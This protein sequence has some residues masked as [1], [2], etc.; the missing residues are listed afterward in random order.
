M[1]VVRRRQE[2]RVEGWYDIRRGAA[3]YA[4]IVG[5]F[6]ALSVPAIVFL[7]TILSSE[8]P[9]MFTKQVPV[10]A[11]A[12]G[13]LIVVVIGS[14]AG[15]IGL[16]AIGAERDATANL[17]PATMFL[18]VAVSISLIAVLAAFEALATLYLPG[19]GSTEVLFVAIV[20]V[21]GATGAFFTALSIADSWQTGPTRGRGRWLRTQWL[22]SYS[23]AYWWAEFVSL[24]SAIPALLGIVL[25]V[26]VWP[27]VGVKIRLTT[28]EATWL[29]GVALA[30]SMAA[31]AMGALR[32]RHSV[33]EAQ[34]GLRQWEALATPLTISC[35]ALA[36]MIFL[37]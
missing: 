33:D 4:P 17:V 13:L 29:V 19:L 34:K 35:Y 10:I 27:V 5:A 3:G 31:I 26:I 23:Q 20:G 30:L 32:T 22:Q 21:G 7:F 25:R 9:R 16:A 37:P 8:P 12:G 24:V 14:L 18:A 1:G 36:L 28:A 2:R 6:G 15:A 11:L